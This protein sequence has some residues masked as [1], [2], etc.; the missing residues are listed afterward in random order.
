MNINLLSPEIPLVQRTEIQAQRLKREYDLINN[1]AVFKKTPL[2][3]G[4]LYPD[5]TSI[6]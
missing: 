4:A 2:V 3:S 6:A 5:T 1:S